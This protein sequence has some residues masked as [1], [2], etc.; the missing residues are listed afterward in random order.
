M[1]EVRTL[2]VTLGVGIFGC[3]YILSTTAM[4]T[5]IVEAYL[6]Y[7]ASGAAAAQL[8]RNVF[9]FAFP[10]FAPS[11]YSS[12]SYGY[13]NTLLAGIACVL[14]IPAPYVLWKYGEYLR[15]KGKTIKYI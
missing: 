9:A 11:L 10:I 13:G 15:R 1:W 7:T 2:T 4:Q 5:Y 3:G 12:L 6:D 8:P 14:G